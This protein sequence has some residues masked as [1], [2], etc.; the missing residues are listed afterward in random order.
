MRLTALVD[1]RLYA[2]QLSKILVTP[3][4]CTFRFVAYRELPPPAQQLALAGA[5]LGVG[6][7][8]V[9]DVQFEASGAATAMASAAVSAVLK[10]LQEDVLQRRGWS[11]LELMYGTWGPQCLLLLA[12]VPLL[13][14]LD[15]LM[16][17]E[18]TTYRAAVISFSALGY[19]TWALTHDQ[20]LSSQSSRHSSPLPNQSLVRAPL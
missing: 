11:S 1:S 20:D 19:Q 16:A 7:A 8:T 18:L 6:L 9:N 2:P 3:L 4:I 15:P 12:S 17:Y 14:A 10:V 5:C 13:D